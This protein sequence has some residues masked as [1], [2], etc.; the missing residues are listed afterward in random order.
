MTYW[1][2]SIFVFSMIRSIISIAAFNF[3]DQ[4]KILAKYPC[5]YCIHELHAYNT[6]IL[7]FQSNFKRQTLQT[8]KVFFCGMKKIFYFRN[9]SQSS[10]E[11]VNT[12]LAKIASIIMKRAEL[13]FQMLLAAYVVFMC[14]M[15]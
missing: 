11:Q 2:K 4:S 7:G 14:G 5:S 9:S 6:H 10:D 1:M 12:S 15:H 8:N 3:L 13:F